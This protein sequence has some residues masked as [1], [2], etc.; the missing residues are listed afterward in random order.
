MFTDTMLIVQE[1]VGAGERI[2]WNAQPKQ[3]LTL[4]P[5]DAFMIPFSLLWGGFAIFWEFLVVTG[6]A[7]FFF[8]LWGIP[9]VLIGLHMIVGRFFVDA[10]Q[11]KR[12]YYALTNERIVI[13]S[14]LFSRNVKTLNLKTLQEINLT[15]RRKGSGTITFGPVDPAAWRTWTTGSNRTRPI[16]S[17]L[18]MIENANEVYQLIRSTQQIALAKSFT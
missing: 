12:T 9:F 13:I 2:L 4:Q 1:E 11:R 7:P 8:A 3:G 14:G 17:S 15:L 6:G 5:S 10:L 16:S 18:V